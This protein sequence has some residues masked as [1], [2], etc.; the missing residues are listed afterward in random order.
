MP[1]IKILKALKFRKSGWCWEKNMRRFK[2]QL[3]NK[4]ILLVP[5]LGV[6]TS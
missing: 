5:P 2:R 3:Y 4:G 6:T 1:Y